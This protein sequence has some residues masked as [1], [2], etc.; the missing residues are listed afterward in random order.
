MACDATAAGL[1]RGGS[2]AAEPL[3]PQGGLPSTDGPFKRRSTQASAAAEAAAA[4]AGLAEAGQGGHASS[5][6]GEGDGPTK[7]YAQRLAGAAGPLRTRGHLAAA[8]CKARQDVLLSVFVTRPAVSPPGLLVGFGVE[9]GGC[10]GAARVAQQGC[11]P[12]HACSA[13]GRRGSVAR[14]P[15]TKPIALPPCCRRCCC[16]RAGVEPLHQRLPGGRRRS[17][18]RPGPLLM[19]TFL[20]R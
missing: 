4:A 18:A 16:C 12:M 11:P 13:L 3:P 15:S 5:S 2:E 6:P 9:W 19:Q 10:C 1:S 14:L 7:T 20:G 17:P 8:L